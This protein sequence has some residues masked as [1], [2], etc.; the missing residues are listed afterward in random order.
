M[1]TMA[2]TA[3]A[4]AG[5]DHDGRQRGASAGIADPGTRAESNL[6]ADRAMA[7]GPSYIALRPVPG[8]VNP[9]HP[10]GN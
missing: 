5:P 2:L 10:L 6:E 9:D 3:I 4:V 8:A 7:V 1:S